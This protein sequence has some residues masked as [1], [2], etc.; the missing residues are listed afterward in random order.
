MTERYKLAF[1]ACAN[2]RTLHSTLCIQLRNA[3]QPC[4][5]SSL[6]AKLGRASL[7]CL[8]NE[9]RVLP[10]SGCTFSVRNLPGL[11]LENYPASIGRLLPTT[12]QMLGIFARCDRTRRSEEHT[13]ELQS[14]VDI[15]C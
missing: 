11:A 3:L 8:G 14:R 15:V 1:V 7:S 9:R 2:R 13:S 10:G 4:D 12:R 5:D 6:Y